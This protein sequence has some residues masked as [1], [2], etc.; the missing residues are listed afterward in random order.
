MAVLVTVSSDN[1]TCQTNGVSWMHQYEM[2]LDKAQR[3]EDYWRN[4][5]ADCDCAPFPALLLSVQQ[6]VA[7]YVMERQII[8]PKDRSL[9]ITAS[10]LVRAAWAL[11]TGRLTDSEDVVFGVMVSG[12]YPPVASIEETAALTI[13]TLLV[14]VKF[15]DDQTVCKYLEAV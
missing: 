6:P 3:M 2:N 9:V 12:R 11:V 14:R 10:N 1:T 13:T 15:A 4:A 8:L 7:D 5:L